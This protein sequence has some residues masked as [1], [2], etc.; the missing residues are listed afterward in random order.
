MEDIKW[1]VKH[2]HKDTYH[3]FSLICVSWKSPMF[4]TLLLEK[5]NTASK[6][7]CLFLDKQKGWT[8]MDKLVLESGKSGLRPSSTNYSCVTSDEWHNQ[9]KPQ[10]PHLKCRTNSSTHVKG[11][12]ENQ[13][14]SWILSVSAVPENVP[15]RGIMS[16]TAVTVVVTNFD[17]VISHNRFQINLFLQSL[18][19]GCR[20]SHR[21]DPELHVVP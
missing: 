15:L 12:W 9:S 16:I 1:N 11:C 10:F 14:R 17:I 20:T 19:R 8:W 6:M 5:R 21:D 7:C 18:S 13:M 4:S 2:I 3:I